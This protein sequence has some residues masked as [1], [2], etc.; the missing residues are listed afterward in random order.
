MPAM[1][2]AHASTRALERDF[3]VVHWDRRDAGKSFDSQ[4]SVENESVSQHLADAEA[5][6][7]LLRRRFGPRPMILLGHSWGTYL[8]VLLAQ[9]HPGWFAAYVG[10]GQVTDPAR[11]HEL[12]EG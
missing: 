3:T 8:A 11:E 7:N 12:V 2:L 4:M 6:V 9:R 5:L 10:M 1:Y